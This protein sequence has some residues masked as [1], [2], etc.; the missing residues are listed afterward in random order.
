ML[1]FAKSQLYATTKY[2]PIPV[3][4]YHAP[5]KDLGSEGYTHWRHGRM[6]VAVASEILKDERKL[7]RLLMHEFTHVIEYLNDVAYLSAEVSEE[8][9][10][11]ARTIE[12]GMS[13]LWE[14][15]I[16]SS[17]RTAKQVRGTRRKAAQR[18][19]SKP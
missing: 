3:P 10:E 16:I 14:N 19:R 7:N 2:G 11:L 9:T 8:C 18:R 4:I 5:R 1:D 13:Q 17:A 12:E 6:E 15:L